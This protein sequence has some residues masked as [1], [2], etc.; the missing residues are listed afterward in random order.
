MINNKTAFEIC[1]IIRFV[2]FL[3][4]AIFVGL[5]FAARIGGI[6]LFQLVIHD[7]IYFALCLFLAL[8]FIFSIT[9]E[10]IKP[11]FVEFDFASDEIVVKTYRPDLYK[12]SAPFALFGYKKRII[13]FKISKEEYND[14]KLTIGKLG[15]YKELKLQKTNNDG[16]YDSPKIN[17]SL[18]GQKK[19]TNLILAVERLRTKISMN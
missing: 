1:L 5:I 9:S 14:Y 19:Y 2:I 6:D 7:F 12:K 8:A 17:I 16:V 11:T 10:I 4:P 18:L 15:I 13:E 3:V